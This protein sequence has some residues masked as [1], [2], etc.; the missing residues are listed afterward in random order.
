MQGLSG[1]IS[2][3]NLM[4]SQIFSGIA[5]EILSQGANRQNNNNVQSNENNNLHNDIDSE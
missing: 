3:Q 2:T 4:R 5:S 1:G